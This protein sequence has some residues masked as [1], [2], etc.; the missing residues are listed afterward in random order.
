MVLK[1]PW[2][3]K[4]MFW[5]FQKSIFQLFA[6]FLVT[7]LIPFSGKERQ[8]VQIY[9]NQNFGRRSF[10]ENGFGATL[11]LKTNVVSVW[12]EHFPVFCK[13]LSEE[14][15][16]I[17]RE[18]EAKHSKLFLSKFGHRK[19]LR[20][21][22]WSY[23]ELKNERCVRLKRAFFS[24]LQI[25]ELRSWNRFLGKRGNAAKSFSIKS[26]LLRAF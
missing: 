4:R 3:K 13:C 5:A 21:Y 16:T 1:L 2:A 19:L 12:K 14:V 6:S 17:F 9:L 20:K 10:L 8:I 22:F 18:S 7:K 23:L 24:F 26:T 25:F 15:K 11:S